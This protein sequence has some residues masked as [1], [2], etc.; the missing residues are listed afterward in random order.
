MTP[1]DSGRAEGPVIVDGSRSRPGLSA[2]AHS[3]GS[4]FPLAEVARSPTWEAPAGGVV[5]KRDPEDPFVSSPPDAPQAKLSAASVTPAPN[6]KSQLVQE[7]SLSANMS[8]RVD[9]LGETINPNNAQ[10]LLE[11]EACV[12]VAK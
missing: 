8:P 2:R 3:T 11:P 5:K 4:I 10:G 6:N 12:F 9:R 7:S 1:P